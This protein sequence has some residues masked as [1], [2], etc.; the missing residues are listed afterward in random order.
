MP[1][2][3]WPADH[4]W[5]LASEIDWDSTI[6]AGSRALIDAVLAFDVVEA[7]AVDADDSLMSHADLINL[8]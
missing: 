5:V 2:L 8:A 7:F 1:Q 3:I 4:A 6:V